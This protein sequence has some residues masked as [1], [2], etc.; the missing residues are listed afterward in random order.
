MKKVVI[1]G[2]GPSGLMAAAGAARA[3]AHTTVLEAGP[4]PGRKLLLTGNGRCNLTNLHE[5]IL[6]AYDSSDPEDANRLLRSVF[7]QFSVQDTLDFFRGEG[8]LTSVEHGSYVY[9]VTG[10]STSVLEVLLRALQALKV[11][12]KYS[13]EVIE[14]EKQDPS[15]GSE[16][17]WNVKTKTWTYTADSVILCCGSRA[18]PSTGSNGSGYELCRMLGIDVTDIL[19]GL[20]AISCSLPA[21]DMK[22]YVPGA[23]KRNSHSAGEQ[24]REDP[25]ASASGTRI[26]ASVTVLVDGEV[27]AEERGQLQFTQQDLSGIVIFNL[28]RTVIRA[29]RRGS[30][31]SL[32]L[33]LIP[34]M[35]QDEVEDVIRSL[36]NKY[37]GISDDKILC[38]LVPSRLIPAVTALSAQ[39]GSS[40]SHVLKQFTLKANGLRDFDSAQVCVGG[41]RTTE[42]NPDTLECVQENLKGIFLTGELIDLDGPCGGYN[43]QWAWSS[44][45]TAGQHAA[46]L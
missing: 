8:L 2:G 43:L 24:Y 27:A 19:P 12:L 9:P 16:H 1:I 41:V 26:F 6:S 34:A 44:G 36:R 40:L 38:G 39:S 17:Q 20:T 42:L 4:K 14:I 35:S 45:Y 3:G 22:A 29:L 21:P 18:V 31:V 46:G 15:Q 23:R 32:C 30:D 25:L 5:E 11:K 37:D 33:D 28:S 13:E 10:Q 7:R